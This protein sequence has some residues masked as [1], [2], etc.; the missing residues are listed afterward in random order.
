MTDLAE[1]PLARLRQPQRRD[2]R[3][4]NGMLEDVHVMGRHLKSNFEF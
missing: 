4:N 2:L 3:A 1:V